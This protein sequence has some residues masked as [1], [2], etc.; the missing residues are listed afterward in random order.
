MIY[1][2]SKMRSNFEIAETVYNTMKD[3]CSK[4]GIKVEEP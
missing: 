3:A 1:Q 4:L 2:H